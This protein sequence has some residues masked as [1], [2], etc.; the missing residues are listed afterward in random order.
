MFSTISLQLLLSLLHHKICVNKCS[1]SIHLK[2]SNKATL[3]MLLNLETL[4]II[5]VRILKENCSTSN[6]ESIKLVNEEPF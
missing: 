5:T 3:E 2:L 4:K 6:F 1:L